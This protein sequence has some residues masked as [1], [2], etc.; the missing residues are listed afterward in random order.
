[1]TPLRQ[2]LLDYLAVRRA[3]GFKLHTTEQLLAQFV[4]FVEERREPHLHI[5]TMLAWATLATQAFDRQSRGRISTT[6]EGLFSRDSVK[7]E[8]GRPRP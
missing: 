7:S 2:A 1:M 3:L 8:D 6:R 4:T 5:T